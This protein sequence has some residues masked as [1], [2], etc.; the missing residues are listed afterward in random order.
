MPEKNNQRT[1]LTRML[2]KNSLIE[3]LHK[4][5]VYQITVSELCDTAELNRST[6]YKYYGNVQDI[7]Q[8]LKDETLFKSSQC[9][10]EMETA[11]VI[12][13]EEPLC[14]LL[15]DIKENREIYR[16]LLDN[17]INEDFPVEMLKETVNFFK[18]KVGSALNSNQLSDYI[19]KY[20]ISGCISVIQNWVS[21][22]MTE[23]P[24]EISRLIYSIS[25]SILDHTHMLPQDSAATGVKASGRSSG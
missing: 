21:G 14:R 2:L 13:G 24:E 23:T 6:F 22:P 16:L 5:P 20:V 11:G 18:L 17:S 9:M 12:N 8:E 3:L 4:K 25:V 7:L 1:R 19:F 10:Q 15:Y